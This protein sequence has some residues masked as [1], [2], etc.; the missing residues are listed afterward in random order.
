MLLSGVDQLF[1]YD[2]NGYK[3][4]F[5]E[6]DGYKIG[7][8]IQKSKV[9][10]DNEDCLFFSHN[11]SLIRFGVADGAGGQPKGKYASYVVANVVRQ[12][13]SEPVLSRIE[14]ANQ[15]VTDL[16]VGARSTLALV[17]IEDSFARFYTVG[18]SEII[19]W[20]SAGR[21]LFSSTPNSPAGLRVEA[22]ALSQE[23]SLYDPERHVVLSLMGDDLIKINCTNGLEIK[24]RHTILVGSD[25]L[26]DNISHREIEDLMSE[27]NFDYLYSMLTE[28]C[29][30]QSE[31]QW[32]K[33]D[34]IAFILL[35]KA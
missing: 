23:E 15:G 31:K 35:T 27:G 26:F 19:H 18:D 34:D 21:T 13:T 4:D 17:E 20:N 14:Q 12:I 11:K 3:S 16:K 24:K 1:L 29:L 7:T 9:G 5:F 28:R 2:V 22:G 33:D 25:G 10:H 6:V 32:K 30:L 8:F